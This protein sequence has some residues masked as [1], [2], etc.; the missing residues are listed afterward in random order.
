MTKLTKSGHSTSKDEHSVEEDQK[1][2]EFHLVMII[3][4]MACHYYYFSYLSEHFFIFAQI[5]MM[6]NYFRTDDGT[7]TFHFCSLIFPSAVYEMLEMV[8]PTFSPFP[9]D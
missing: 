6:T 7:L 2:N 8:G 4:E 5:Y 3:V 1:E 9:H